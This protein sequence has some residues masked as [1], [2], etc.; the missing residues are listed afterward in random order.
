MDGVA[1][2]EIAIANGSYLVVVNP[3]TQN[4]ASY[5]IGTNWSILSNGIQ[6]FNG[7]AGNDIALVV[8]GTGQ[9]RIVHPVDG[10]IDAYST[11][12]TGSSWSLTGYTSFN[13]YIRINIYSYSLNRNLVVDDKLFTVM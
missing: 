8:G 3:R 1:G 12:S 10:S 13:G 7:R 5:L 6:N 4:V 11:G 2:A 9:L